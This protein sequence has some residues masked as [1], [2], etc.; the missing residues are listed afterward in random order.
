MWILSNELKR[1]GWQLEVFVAIVHVV[2]RA[3]PAFVIVKF[4]HLV[5][6]EIPTPIAVQKTKL[7]R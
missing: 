3:N 6:R 4:Q 5:N 2:I 7:S 1:P